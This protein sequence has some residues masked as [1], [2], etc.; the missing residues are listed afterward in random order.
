MIDPHRL[1]TQLIRHLYR[2]STRDLAV[3]C[4]HT[5]LIAAYLWFE[6]PLSIWGAWFAI[7]LLGGFWHWYR[8]IRALSHI[9]DDSIKGDTI[10]PDI[11]AAG[12][13]GL[14]LGAAA[15]L[16]PLLSIH[17]R[18][19]VFMMLGAVA[20]AALPRLSTLPSVY[21][22][23]LLGI[24]LPLISILVVMDNEPNLSSIPAVLILGGSLFYSAYRLHSDLMDGLLS[25]F[26]LENEAGQ[27]KLTGLANRRRFDFVLQQEWAH[28]L[29]YGTPIS[30]I[31]MDIDFFK[32]FNDH[33]GHQEGDDCLEQVAGALA[34]SV[35][36]A[37]DLVARYGGEE[38]VVLLSKTARDD[39]Y[40]IGERM[41]QAVEDL[42]IAHE[43][44]T[45][46][47]VTISLGGFTTF[48][49]EDMKAEDL[50]KLADKALY[51]S[52]ESGRNRVT[53]YD[54]KLDDPETAEL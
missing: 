21:A 40:A 18:L 24:M 54:P 30:L 20:A 22:A 7:A 17:T 46:G 34:E 8:S 39:A 23:F 2:H 36:R 51:R 16:F 42:E 3:H 35:K 44:S 43:Q 27:D 48:A 5:S 32:K 45:L 14:S 12:I 50:V 37:I 38:F 33:Y 26:G 28:A 10:I 9:P 41:R 19:F 4:L 25:R 15:L 6:L 29:R 1:S 52:K 49:R 13:A 47:H 31:I 53:W 11:V